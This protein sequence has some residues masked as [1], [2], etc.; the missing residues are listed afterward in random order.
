M[1]ESYKDL[2]IY[3]VD[4]D[5]F[6]LNIYEQQVKNFGFKYVRTFSSGSECLGS[7]ESDKPDLVFLDHDMDDMKGLDVLKIIKKQF[8]NTYVVMLSGQDNIYI[9]IDAVKSGAFEYIVKGEQDM[10]KITNVLD[11]ISHIKNILQKVEKWL[12]QNIS[13]VISSKNTT[14][15]NKTISIK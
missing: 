11:K 10:E 2:K 1:M 7:L 5:M 4:D 3:L 8:P 13:N 9:A 14:T 12:I 15:N 6:C